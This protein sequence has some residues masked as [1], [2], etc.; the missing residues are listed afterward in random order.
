MAEENENLEKDKNVETKQEDVLNTENY[1]KAIKE[2]KS[3]S[4]SK[5]AYN[6]LQ[7]DNKMLLNALVNGQTP[8]TDKKEEKEVDSN[9]LRKDLFNH[10]TLTNLQYVEKALALRSELIKRGETDPFLPYGANI[11]PEPDDI[12]KANKVAEILKECVD[13]A[14]GDS[15]V[16]T[17]EL[18]R[19]M[20]DVNIPIKR[21]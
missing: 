12:T 19:R 20:V 7:E 21:R 11:K 3:N 16:F 13:Y 8:E 14:D 10:D 2:M 9:Q 15:N 6:K 1:I 4:V 17:N 5:E 18:Q